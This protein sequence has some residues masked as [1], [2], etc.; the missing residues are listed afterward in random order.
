[1]IANIEKSSCRPCCAV[2]FREGAKDLIFLRI[3]PRAI[4]LRD[5][6]HL[7]FVCLAFSS[8]AMENKARWKVLS[9]N[10]PHLRLLGSIAITSTL[11]WAWLC[12]SRQFVS[13][14]RVSRCLMASKPLIVHLSTTSISRFYNPKAC[15][16][17]HR[18]PLI[19]NKI[20]Y[21]FGFMFVACACCHRRR[22]G[23]FSPLLSLYDNSIAERLEWFNRLHNAW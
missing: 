6:S 10:C 19:N 12:T 11:M 1:M 17:F 4:P 15:H 18:V 21:D 5:D 8:H 13:R 23:N 2:L 3:S 9:G 22:D 16:N 14:H 7:F 20:D